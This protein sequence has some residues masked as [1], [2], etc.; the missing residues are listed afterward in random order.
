[1]VIGDDGRVRV[2]DFG[3]A[4]AID[5]S[6][7]DRET[8]TR[9]S[10]RETKDKQPRTTY[11]SSKLLR[12]AGISE[13]DT[14]LSQDGAIVGTPAYMAPEQHVGADVDARSDLFCFCIALWEALYGQHPYDTD[15]RLDMIYALTSGT[16]RPPPADR[17]IPRWLHALLLRGLRPDPNDRP[18]SMRELIEALRRG[19]R[20]RRQMIWITTVGILLAISATM[21]W[22][23]LRASATA[24]PPCQGA[25]HK[26]A[27]IWDAE[28]EAALAQSFA[29]SSLP[30]AESTW[31]ALRDDLNAYT[32]A[33]TTMR[34]D[35]CEATRVHHEQSAELMDLRMACLDG[36]LVEFNALTEVLAY[37]GDEAA[38]VSRARRAASA[39]P[40]LD[41]CADLQA[42][43]SGVH[44]PEDLARRRMIDDARTRLARVR[45]RL[46]AGQFAKA[47]ELLP[48]VMAEAKA[49]D[50]APVLAEATVLRGKLLD[51]NGDVDGAESV[52]IDAT[53]LALASRQ[54]RL[55]SDAM[56]ELIY[57][58]GIRQARA[59]EALL[60]SRLAAATLERIKPGRERDLLEVRRLDREGLVLAQRGELD[61]GRARQEQALALAEAKIGPQTIDS[62]A[63]HLNLSSTLADLGKLDAA[64]VH[65]EAAIRIF[66]AEIGGDHPH[67]AIALNNLGALADS[68][69]APE[70]AIEHHRRALA[71]KIRSLGERHPSTANSHNN[72]A[73][74]M[75]ALGDPEGAV[76]HVDLALEIKRE[77]YGKDSPW[78]AETLGLRAEIELSRG[79]AAAAAAIAEQAQQ[80]AAGLGDGK[81]TPT[82]IA[83]HRIAGEAA[84]A[85]GD[86]DAAGQHFRKALTI[87]EEIGGE[88][89]HYA[90]VVVAYAAMLWQTENTRPRAREVINRA[91]TRDSAGE[92]ALEHRREDLRLWLD[93]HTVT[94][95]SR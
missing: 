14:R 83:L 21:T 10:K 85:M 33:W 77:V 78:L 81:A 38:I 56:V 4:R 35:T 23:A 42:L 58:V 69:G 82:L 13:A 45:A 54:D 47:L 71:I 31:A 84:A 51:R 29:E 39:L 8:T 60:W 30:Y 55:A 87:Y 64:Q 90:D 9:G 76:P 57:T 44:L 53:V 70:Q 17:R 16:L 1:M 20:R 11:T 2:L 66:V 63:I 12:S 50:Y 34:V 80:L 92:L 88:P 48:P 61:N 18:Q 19:R 40:A 74:T 7:A 22:A 36:H 32:D 25:K 43:T 27:G 72:I 91:L 49:T 3:L 28:V 65:L 67:V 24:P 73:A 95:P 68:L 93:K 52:L 86:P 46:N 89:E 37:A 6:A 5:E 41:R 75:L 62:A 59:D 79:K 26:L 94:E 15:S